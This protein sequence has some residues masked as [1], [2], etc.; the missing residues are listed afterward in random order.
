MVFKKNDRVYYRDPNKRG[1]IH[2]A[3]VEDLGKKNGQAIVNLD[4][5]H[6]C[7]AHDVIAPNDLGDIVM[8]I[9]SIL[10][11]TYDGKDFAL[12]KDKQWDAETIE[13]VAGV[14]EDARLAPRAAAE[15][16]A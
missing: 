11:Q 10:W 6:W 8:Q 4:N 16:H 9:Q 14:L 5:G 3:I 12:S 1:A 2:T 15:A 13:A 7:Y